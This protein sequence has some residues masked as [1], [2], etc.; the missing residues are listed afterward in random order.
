MKRPIEFNYSGRLSVK[1]RRKK[2]NENDLQE[3]EKSIVEYVDGETQISKYLKAKDF[4]RSETAFQFRIDNR[5]PK[6]LLSNAKKIGQQYDKIYEKFNGNIMLSSAYRCVKLN[7]KVGGSTTSQ[8][9]DALA[10]DI[11]GKNGVKNK[12]ILD[13]VRYNLTYQQLIS[14]FGTMTEPAWVHMG[15]GTRMQYFR[16]GKSISKKLS[17]AINP[18]F[19]I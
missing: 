3:N 8:H 18:D 9:K 1:P 7:K 19:D 4:T 11:K 17:R 10:I 6:S 14:E 16:L 12:Q 2:E 5:L 15:Y 13:W